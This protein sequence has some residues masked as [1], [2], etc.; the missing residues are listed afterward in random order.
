MA[1][2][3]THFPEL[4]DVA[5]RDGQGGLRAEPRAIVRGEDLTL[6][7]SLPAHTLFGDWTAG[8]FDAVLRA[9]PG[10]AGD[11]L[12]EYT[13]EAGAPVGLLTPIIMTLAAAD[14]AD[15]PPADAGTG[16]AEVFLSV[17][18]TAPGVSRETLITT[19]Q[20][21]RGS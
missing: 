17:G 15:L 2:I 12:A 4:L 20:L 5:E 21:V 6:T 11:P 18:Y 19:R 7:F 8:T 9:A 1:T 10:A 14:H 13:I 16:I 3:I